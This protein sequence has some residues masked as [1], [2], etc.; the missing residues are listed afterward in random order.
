MRLKD[1]KKCPRCNT[2]VAL[3]EARCAGCGLIFERLNKV[4]NRAGKLALKR[5][6][7]NKVI[8]VKKLPPDVN[9]VKLLLFAIFLGFFGVQY[10][11][12]G[13]NKMF[14]FSIISFV[15]LFIYTLLNFLPFIPKWIFTDKYIGLILIFMTFPSAFAVIFWFASIFQIIFNRFKVPVS[16]DEDYVLSEIPNSDVA[17]DIINQVKKSRE[18]NEKAVKTKQKRKYFCANCGIYVKLQKGDYN[19]PICNE[20]LRNDEDE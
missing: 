10:A 4:T 3:N 12:V 11:K 16:I 14:C 8:Y 2:K 20:R 1:Y 18:E 5:K 19:C 13:R 6:E 9:K 17:K 15:L 7:Y